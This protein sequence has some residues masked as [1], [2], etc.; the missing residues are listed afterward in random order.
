MNP[1]LTNPQPAD[2]RTETIEPIPYWTRAGIVMDE[3]PP[4]YAAA[5]AET[6]WKN[7]DKLLD[8]HGNK[9]KAI[10]GGPTAPEGCRV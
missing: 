4:A 7:W 5:M 3:P 10:I 1:T 9:P 8:K 2:E 6:D